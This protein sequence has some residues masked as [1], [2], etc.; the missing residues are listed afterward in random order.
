MSVLHLVRQDVLML[1]GD[2]TE[3]LP[4]YETWLRSWG[5]AES[6]IRIRVSVLERCLEETDGSPASLA[7]WLARYPAPW[8]K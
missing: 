4:T 6:T 8:T 7:E 3:L 2:V 5:A 1:H